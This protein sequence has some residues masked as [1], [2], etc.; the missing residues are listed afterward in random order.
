MH[1]Y[2]LW[3]CRNVSLSL[4]IVVALSSYCHAMVCY[5]F[6]QT[7]FDEGATVS[8]WFCGIDS[9][10]DGQIGK[11]FR[12]DERNFVNEL[13]ELSLSFSGNSLVPAFTFDLDDLQGSR[14]IYENGPVWGDD[15]S[16]YMSIE[17]MVGV[18]RTSPNEVFSTTQFHLGVVS[19]Y[20]EQFTSQE[21][22]III[23]NQSR[24]TNDMIVTRKP[25]AVPEP[26]SIAVWTCLAGLC[27]WASRGRRMANESATS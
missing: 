2:H 19:Y 24:S 7:G 14:Y 15:D 20:F 3:L 10:S 4:L 1:A 22:E 27:L 11:Y 17:R 25:A 18:L 21:N 13:S 12:F 5:E 9:N 23:N 6:E 16:E 8:G 26:Q